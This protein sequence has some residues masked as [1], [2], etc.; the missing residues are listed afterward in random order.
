MTE[1]TRITG[2]DA[3]LADYAHGRAPEPVRVLIESHLELSPA[4]RAWIQALEALGG[5]G[6]EAVKPVPVE[7]R[8]AML[9]RVLTEAGEEPQAVRR[10]AVATPR[11]GDARLPE[12]FRRYLGMPLDRVPWQG[13]SPGLREYQIPNPDGLEVSLISLESGHAFPRHTHGGFELLLVLEGSY[14]DET[15]R[16]ARGDIQWSDNTLEHS[17]VADPGGDCIC[18]LVVDAPLQFT[19]V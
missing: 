2:L 15:G 18:F 16:Y 10:Q 6:L 5:A 7:N 8:D 11:A 9:A 4:N 13:L 17:P 19:D 12:P 3:L 1:E 14:T